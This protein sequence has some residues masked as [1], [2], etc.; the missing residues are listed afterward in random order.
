MRPW[1]VLLVCLACN[2]PAE[3][4]DT[5]VDTETGTET[6]VAVD[7]SAT[8][9]PEAGGTLTLDAFVLDVPAGAVAETVDITARWLT[10][11][12]LAEVSPDALT[13]LELGPD[14]LAFSAPATASMSFSLAELGMD[15]DSDEVLVHTWVSVTSDG[16]VDD[17]LSF[18]PT[19]DPDA[20]PTMALSYD[21][22]EGA[23]HGSVAHFSKLIVRKAY[24]VDGL[25]VQ[26]GY[27]PKSVQAHVGEVW[28][29]HASVKNLATDGFVL[30]LLS[31]TVATKS[32]AGDF[33]ISARDG[34]TWTTGEDVYV[35]TRTPTVAPGARGGWGAFQVGCTQQGTG[36]FTRDVSFW[37]DEE[38]VTS[39]ADPG[40]IRF[41]IPITCAEAGTR[42]NRCSPTLPKADSVARL[43]PKLNLSVHDCNDLARVFFPKLVKHSTNNTQPD[44]APA[45]DHTQVHA[46]TASIAP[47]TAEEIVA[48]FDADAGA[49]PCG[50]GTEGL[51]VCPDVVPPAVADA[52]LP[53]AGDFVRSV[54]VLDAD[55]PTTDGANFLE[56]AF[57]FDADG[58][59]TDNWVGF[60]DYPNDF[61]IGA[62]RWYVAKYHPT[63]GWSLAVSHAHGT[64]ITPVS[65]TAR[66]VVVEN[67][68]LLLAPTSEFAVSD[69]AFRV[70]AFR[71]TGDYGIN[72]PYDWNG[73]IVPPVADGLAP[74]PLPIPPLP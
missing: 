27:L 10:A 59:G 69:P 55:V 30:P 14:G 7:A 52:T 47:L 13:G 25:K 39:D 32:I 44:K 40:R 63:S 57:V 74:F 54:I 41:R 64:T 21:E 17:T 3:T 53:P 45:G 9:T 70:T 58:D 51:T 33:S 1:P 28:W 31:L 22:D 62:D 8:I 36:S 67:V 46:K 19:D 38:G 26:A 43:S 6:D 61:F 66:V 35:D 73:H 4:E 5:V 60:P 49:F 34:S 68:V 48:A 37:T 42:P 2:G 72:P 24:D 71:H 11:D 12:E 20:L 23:V 50:Q 29:P 15:P 18:P 16:A 65:S 56:Y